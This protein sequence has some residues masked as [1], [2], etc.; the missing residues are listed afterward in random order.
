LFDAGFYGTK[1]FAFEINNGIAFVSQKYY[2]NNDKDCK[3]ILQLIPLD[4]RDYRKEGSDGR[5]PPL[6]RE[7]MIRDLMTLNIIFGIA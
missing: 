7:V 4:D 5:W 6:V 3:K 2:K 1:I